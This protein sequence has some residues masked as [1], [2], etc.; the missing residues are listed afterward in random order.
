MSRQGEIS[1]SLI[2]LVCSYSDNNSLA[3]SKLEMGGK[4]FHLPETIPLEIFQYALRCI[5]RQMNLAGDKRLTL[6]RWTMA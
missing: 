4:G 2:F 3:A 6:A 1:S 5:K